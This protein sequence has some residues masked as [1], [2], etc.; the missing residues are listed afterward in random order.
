MYIVCN[1][2]NPEKLI[3]MINRYYNN[4]MTAYAR[5][6]VSVIDSSGKHYDYYFV[7]KPTRK[8]ISKCVR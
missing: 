5:W 3:N 6:Q 2:Y 4:N 7:S 8:Q 1:R